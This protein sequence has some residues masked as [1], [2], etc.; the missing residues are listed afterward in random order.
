MEVYGLIGN[1]VGHSH[2]PPMQEAGFEAAGI[3]ARYV[4]F[5]PERDAGREAIEAAAALGVSGLNVTI[6]FKEQVLEV[7]DADEMAA[8]V[9][10][11]NTVDLDTNPPGGYNTDVEGA[12]RAL[13]HH[14]VAIEG[15]RA[16]V[17]GAGGAGR[18][19]TFGLADEGANVAVAN[20][21]LE[22]ASNLADELPSV[23]AHGLDELDA[24]VRE[25]DILVQATSVGMES[26]ESVV[27]AGAL[28]DQLAVMDAVYQ[29]LETRLLREAERAGTRTI[30]GAWML[31]YQ[32]VGAFE[33]WTGVDA[34]IE[35]MNRALRD[36]VRTR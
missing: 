20:R 18:G 21:T 9:G 24:L 1:P 22:R 11:V 19:I 8:T 13:R 33:R 7:V 3:D 28:H 16:V 15:Q 35:A 6:P 14:D 32:G 25:A 31:L 34:P 5:E 12:I 29:P 23:S 36:S 2:S 4:T 27:P 10:A 17:V 30:D 26:D